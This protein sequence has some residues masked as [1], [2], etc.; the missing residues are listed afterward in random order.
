MPAG[1]VLKRLPMEKQAIDTLAGNSGGMAGT[2]NALPRLSTSRVDRLRV[3]ARLLL[4]I[5]GIK[6]LHA[7]GTDA[8]AEFRSRVFTDVNFQRVP[9][10]FVVP[11][12]LAGRTNR[13]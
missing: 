12:L 11:N 2:A 6:P 5:L 4:Y 13:Q 3:S 9:V 1:N 8:M 10:A 7:F